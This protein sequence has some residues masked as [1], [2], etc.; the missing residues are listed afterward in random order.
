MKINLTRIIYPLISPGLVST[1]PE[2][3]E[4][5]LESATTDIEPKGYDQGPRVSDKELGA[6]VQPATDWVGG[7]VEEAV[8]KSVGQRLTCAGQKIVLKIPKLGLRPTDKDNS[9]KRK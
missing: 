2:T 6:G 7:L 8:A 3:C 5:L 4:E 9:S 1:T